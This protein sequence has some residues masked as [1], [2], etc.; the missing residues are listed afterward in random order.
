M[1]QRANHEPRPHSA[2]CRRPDA[3]RSSAR[4]AARIQL[5]L[6]AQ[7]NRRRDPGHPRRAYDRRLQI[8]R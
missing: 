6:Q 2:D 7:G 5:G 3:A 4:V 8:H 1:R